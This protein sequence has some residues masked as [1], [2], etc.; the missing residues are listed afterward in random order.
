MSAVLA[1]WRNGTL[2]PHEPV[3]WPE[4]AELRVEL[5][6]EDPDRQETPE[7]I[8]Q[9]IAEYK[10]LPKLD[11][12]EAEINAFYKYLAEKKEWELAGHKDRMER[13]AARI[14]GAE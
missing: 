11:M 10:A 4:G 6:E 1:T 12:T 5:A 7:E 9:W 14:D 3:D 2:L 8:E 13:L